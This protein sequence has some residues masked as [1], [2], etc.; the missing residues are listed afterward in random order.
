MS[1]DSSADRF[2]MAEFQR[3]LDFNDRLLLDS[4][5]RISNVREKT[6][7]LISENRKSFSKN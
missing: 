4:G 5:N 3:R 2:L 1:P 7:S 6:K